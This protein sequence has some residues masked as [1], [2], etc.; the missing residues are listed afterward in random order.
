M[1]EKS[2]KKQKNLNLLHRPMDPRNPR[3]RTLRLVQMA[4]LV[5]SSSVLV[6]LSFPILPVVPFMEYDLA[7]IPV[8]LCTFTMGTPAGL[9][10]LTIAALLQAFVFA[11][12]GIIGF[13]MHMISSGIWVLLAGGIYSLCKR[14]TKGMV[15]GLVCGTIAV[16]LVMIPLNFIF[17]PVLMN[18]D[19]SVAETASIFW[20]GLFGGYDPAAYSEAAIAMHDTVAGLLW[21]GIIPFNLIKW[22]LHSVIFVI[23]YRSL[24][25]LHR[26]KQQAE[27]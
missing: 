4:V 26:H 17:I 19:L 7:D 27:V 15:L 9:L 23:V 25:F 20:Q 3:D 6:L 18:A 8:L 16:V 21:I 1:K 12:N 22:V 5:A 14:T 10:V 11:H 2:L 13:I 24:P